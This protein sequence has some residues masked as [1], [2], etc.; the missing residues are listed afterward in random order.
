[1]QILRLQ[2]SV[3]TKI[4][5]SYYTANVEKIQTSLY[6]KK[7]PQ[8]VCKGGSV[9]SQSATFIFSQIDTSL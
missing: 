4:H 6:R 9:R 2:K 5:T 7:L 3:F 1:M 8:K